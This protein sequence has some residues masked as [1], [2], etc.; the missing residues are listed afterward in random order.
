MAE[1]IRSG[2][3]GNH[4]RR[5]RNIYCKRRDSLV[6]ALHEYFGAVHLSGLESGLHLTWHLPDNYPDASELQ[7]VAQRHGIGIYSVGAAT[8]YDYG[9]CAYSARTLVLGF[10]SLNEYQIRAGMRRLADAF[11]DLSVDSLSSQGNV[12][13]IATSYL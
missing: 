9:N 8:G 5:M 2:A 6:D 4:L 7:A 12:P 3:Y 11:V 1:F 13:P 10:S